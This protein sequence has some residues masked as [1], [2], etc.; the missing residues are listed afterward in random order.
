MKKLIFIGLML[1]VL[2]TGLQFAV[3]GGAQEGKAQVVEFVAMWN[4]GEPQADFFKQMAE[5][6][7]METGIKVKL[8]LAGRDSLIKIRGR[9]LTNDPPDL[10]DHD[11]N[12]L[13]AALLAK[14]ILSEPINDFIYNTKGPEGQA[15]MM[16]LFHEDIVKLYEKDGKLYFFPYSFITSGFFYDKNLFKKYNLKTP[17]TWSEFIKVNETLKKNGIAPLGQDGTEHM[18]NAYYYYWAITRVLGPGALRKA[19]SDATGKTWDDPGYLKA[20]ELVYELSKAQKNHFQ[21]GYEGSTWPAGQVDWSLGRSGSLLC[22]NWIPS[23]T[24]A[25][26]KEGFEYGFYPFPEIEGAKGKI[27]DVEAYLIGFTI[28]K[29]AKNPEGAKKFMEFIIKKE[30]AQKFVEMSDNISARKNI[31]YPPILS[32]VKAVVDSATHFHKMYDGAL[33][34]LPEWFA[35]AFYPVDSDLIWGRITPNEFIEKIKENTVKYWKTK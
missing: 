16:D 10:M 3:A 11:F 7:E 17:K 32:D 2:L 5:A 4:E 28:L 14:E 29:G 12:E 21:D 8:S 27:T 30:Y 24:R 34:D 6:F 31:A 18:Y 13:N 22:G 35:S 9:L 15:R 26:A 25:T 20:A 19:A 33:S 1:T 23:E